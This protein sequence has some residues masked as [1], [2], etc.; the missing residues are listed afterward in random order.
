MKIC[1]IFYSIQGETSYSGLPCVFVRTSGCNLRC[2]YCDTK[3]AYEGGV[4]TSVDQILAQVQSY[5]CHLVTITGGEPLVQRDEVNSLIAS[6]LEKGYTILLETNGS[7]SVEGVDSRVRKIMDLKC[8]D[9]GMSEHVCW[10][11]LQHLN[12][13]DQAKFVIGS[14]RD[15]EWAR[16]VI[17][18]YPILNE[19]ESLLSAAFD[20]VEARDIVKWML[21][22]RLNA[23]FQLQIHK[24]IWSPDARGV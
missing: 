23:R 9:S 16:E 15:Y 17:A 2:S 7:L 1:E 6:L 22:D 20:T 5:G 19:L 24:Y 8:P 14:R 21:A 4:E 18:K 12:R 10:K 13:H 3:Y 11:N